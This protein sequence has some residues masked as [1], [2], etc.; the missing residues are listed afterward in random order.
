MKRNRT[1]SVYLYRYYFRKQLKKQNM[2]TLKL[3]EMLRAFVVLTVVL[4][5]NAIALG[6]GNVRFEPL[7]AEGKVLVALEEVSGNK[8]E[9]SIEDANENVVFYSSNLEGEI[10]FKKVFN[11]S[12]LEDGNYCFIADFGTKTL[13]HDF[14]VVDSKIVTKKED[15]GAISQ[16]MFRVGE[17][18]K[19]IVI[20]QSP[21]NNNVEVAFK[22]SETTVFEHTTNEPKLA[23]K[24]D[25]EKLP[26]GEYDVVLNSGEHKYSYSLLVK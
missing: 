19:L 17:D 8:V 9:I 12:S 2:K 4:A 1:R 21:E 13:R 7:S 20:Y 5:M 22:D 3:N 6:S 10:E 14:K 16:P 24:F 25:I 11:V 26:A 15:L 23:A 18:G